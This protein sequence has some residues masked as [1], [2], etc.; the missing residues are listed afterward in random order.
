MLA[1]KGTRGQKSLEQTQTYTVSGRPQRQSVIKV[2]QRGGTGTQQCIFR[3]SDGVTV[4]Y[5]SFS[6]LLFHFFFLC[7]AGTCRFYLQKKYTL[8]V[9]LQRKLIFQPLCENK[10]LNALTV[11]EVTS[12]LLKVLST[13]VVSHTSANTHL[14]KLPRL[15]VGR[16]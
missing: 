14:T 6:K 2:Q 11:N 5:V 16:Q 15:L 13:I 8:F 4:R 10:D 12:V 9:C 1:G 7:P 3:R